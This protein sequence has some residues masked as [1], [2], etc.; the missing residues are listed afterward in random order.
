MAATVDAV[1]S[2]TSTEQIVKIEGDPECAA[3]HGSLCAK[4]LAFTQLVYHPDRLKY[5]LKRV[6]P[7]GEGTWQRI[8]WDEALDAIADRLSEI[9]SS[10]VQSRWL[11]AMAPGETTRR[12]CIALQICSARPTLSPRGTVLRTPDS[13]DIDNLWQASGL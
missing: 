5:P 9:N 4:G 12:T 7:R 2:C 13:G 3:N 8:S 11:L 10:S 1:C 6:G